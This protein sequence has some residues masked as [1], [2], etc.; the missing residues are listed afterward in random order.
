MQVPFSRRFKNLYKHLYSLQCKIPTLQPL[1]N[2]QGNFGVLVSLPPR[3][4]EP[5]PPLLTSTTK[6]PRYQTSVAIR[7]T[8]A[9]FPQASKCS[10][11]EEC[12]LCFL[13][14]CIRL[15]IYNKVKSSSWLVWHGHILMA[16]KLLR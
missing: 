1:N 16:N 15:H 3:T 6:S 10:L 7:K 11:T 5:P 4:W 12:K 13:K 9:L 2:E 14:L 8:K